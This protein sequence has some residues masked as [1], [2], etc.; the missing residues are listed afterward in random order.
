MVTVAPI[1]VVLVGGYI[2]G[3]FVLLIERYAYGNK[4]KYRPSGIVR[5]PWQN[6]C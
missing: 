2:I 4:L 3:I 1:L 6:E 5:R